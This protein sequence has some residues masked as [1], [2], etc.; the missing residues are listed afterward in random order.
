MTAR[1]RSAS[2][3]WF[4]ASATDLTN[5]GQ[6]ICSP[7]SAFNAFGNPAAA[8]GRTGSPMTTLTARR[9]RDARDEERG[10]PRRRR[11]PPPAA[12]ETINKGRT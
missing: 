10:R 9:D 11:A 8:G 1:A 4:Q 6:P 7:T 3:I 5:S 12:I 2:G